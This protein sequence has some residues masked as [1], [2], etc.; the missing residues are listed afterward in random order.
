MLGADETD[1]C[2][3]AGPAPW[4]CSASR[5]A[6]SPTASRSLGHSRYGV[7]PASVFSSWDLCYGKPCNRLSRHPRRCF[8]LGFIAWVAS[9]AGGCSLEGITASSSV[10]NGTE[11]CPQP[12][13]VPLG[14]PARSAPG[15]GVLGPTLA[16]C[17]VGTPAWPRPGPR[18]ASGLWQHCSV[19]PVPAASR[20]ILGSRIALE[21]S[22]GATFATPLGSPS[23]RPILAAGEMLE[24]LSAPANATSG[25][26]TREITNN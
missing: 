4:L 12:K 26:D 1:G 9:G 22:V 18:M 3:R 10:S 16:W 15:W 13:H 20:C 23:I 8:P 6:P 7:F 2:W 24:N 21:G 19:P 11:R 17:R 5:S 25:R 14:C